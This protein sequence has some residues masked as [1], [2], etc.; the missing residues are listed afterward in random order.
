MKRLKDFSRKKIREIATEYATTSLA[1]NHSY[2]EKEYEISEATFYNIL[3]K[4]IV[5]SIV[6]DE[7][8]KCIGEKAQANSNQKAGEYAK[9]RTKRHHEH[10]IMKR[11]TFKFSKNYAKKIAIMYSKS[12]L[13]KKS[14]CNANV[15]HARLFDDALVR[16]VVENWIDDGTYE[17]IKAKAFKNHSSSS[18]AYELFQKLDKI[19]NNH[20]EKQR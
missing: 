19:R 10:L 7:I 3:Q 13:D 2:F 14:F 12:N 5:E 20:K 9:I 16:A 6:N 1:Y 4:S 11:K 15:I 8:A 18:K 17:K